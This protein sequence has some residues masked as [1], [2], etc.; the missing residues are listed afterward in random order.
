MKEEQASASSSSPPAT[1]SSLW[2]DL[3]LC[4]PLDFGRPG[5]REACLITVASLVVAVF[6]WLLGLAEAVEEASSTIIATALESFVDVVS[7]AAVLWR[8]QK[9]NAF[10]PT[11][12]NDQLEARTS[13]VVSLCMMV[14]AGILIAFAIVHLVL[15]LGPSRLSISFEVMLSFPSAVLY[16]VLGMM[17]LQMGWTMRVRSLTQDGLMSILGAATSLGTLLGALVNLMTCE[18]KEAVSFQSNQSSDQWKWERHGYVWTPVRTGGGLVP[19]LRESVRY[20]DYWIEDAITIVLASCI[21]LFGA[22]EVARDTRA[23]VRWYTVAFWCEPPADHTD[24]AT[25]G[26]GARAAAD[27]GVGSALVDET[28]GGDERKEALSETTPLTSAISRGS[29]KR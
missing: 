12:E 11:A 6:F 5:Q 16:L 21:F 13:V 9:R 4:Q 14:L 1:S 2:D 23:G 20:P 10:E 27:R 8:L 28:G 25:H 22:V 19:V 18:Y 24:G 3:L 17:Q 29:A 26:G 7:T 15:Q